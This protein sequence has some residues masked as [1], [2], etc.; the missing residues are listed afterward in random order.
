MKIILQIIGFLYIAILAIVL[1]PI[2]IGLF[3]IVGI[4]GFFIACAEYLITGRWDPFWGNDSGK[5]K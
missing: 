1:A 2:A 3:L 4:V 5:K